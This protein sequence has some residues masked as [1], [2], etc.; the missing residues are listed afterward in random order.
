[1]LPLS[2]VSDTT[3][4]VAA[5]AA[6]IPG[7]V[8]ATRAN[9][10]ARLASEALRSHWLRILARLRRCALLGVGVPGVF[11]PLAWTTV[12]QSPTPGWRE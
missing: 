7:S 10:P 11:L 9:T 4:V 1:M 6:G 3:V 12:A 8:D 5:E 2:K